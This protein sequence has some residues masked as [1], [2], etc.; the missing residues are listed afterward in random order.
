MKMT[1]TRKALVSQIEKALERGR[2]HVQNGDKRVLSPSA[3]QFVELGARVSSRTGTDVLRYL[4]KQLDEGIPPFIPSPA[5]LKQSQDRLSAAL[6]R[7]RVL[8]SRG[9]G[10]ML[11]RTAANASI[12]YNHLSEVE[13][14]D[15]TVLDQLTKELG[16]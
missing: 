16:G 13:L 6:K 11:P 7:A 10:N 3:L 8:W 5:L 2:K 4:A 12:R 9:D 15:A 14:M 1:G